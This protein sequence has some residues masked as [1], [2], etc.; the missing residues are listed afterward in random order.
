[1]GPE[2]G[3]LWHGLPYRAPGAALSALLYGGLNESE[4]ALVGGDNLRRLLK[5]VICMSEWT[6]QERAMRGCRSITSWL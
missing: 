6:I 1:M 2:P 4:L 3:A 5:E